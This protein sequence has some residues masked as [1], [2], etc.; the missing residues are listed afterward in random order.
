MFAAG[1]NISTEA[2]YMS[3]ME[4]CDSELLAWACREAVWGTASSSCASW[5]SMCM[6]R[7]ASAC[8]PD[9]C[10]MDAAGCDISAVADHVAAMEGCDVEWLTA[11]CREVV[12]GTALSSCASWWI[13]CMTRAA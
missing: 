4:G 8:A 10:H 5:W 9:T 2:S 7:A 12:L 1:H 11:A 3:V 13:T 6:A